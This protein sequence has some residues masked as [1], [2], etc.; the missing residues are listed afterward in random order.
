MF[1]IKQTLEFT[2]AAKKKQNNFDAI[3]NLEV[4]ELSLP[5]NFLNYQLGTDL[6]LLSDEDPDDRLQLAVSEDL[7]KFCRFNANLSLANF[8]FLNSYS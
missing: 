8:A 5:E 6:H 7:V 4:P 2:A 1:E 3:E